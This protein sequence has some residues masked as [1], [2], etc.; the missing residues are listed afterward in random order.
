V[1]RIPP[2]LTAIQ[3]FEIEAVCL[4]EG[5]TP[6]K[7]K[8]CKSKTSRL[9]PAA[10][11]K[12]PLYSRIE[13]MAI[14]LAVVRLPYHL[15]RS[16]TEKLGFAD[17]ADAFDVVHVA[18]P[19]RVLLWELP[20][21]LLWLTVEDIRDGGPR[22]PTLLRARM[23]A[24]DPDATHIVL[25]GSDETFIPKFKEML[26][27][28]AD[29]DPKKAKKPLMTVCK[30]ANNKYLLH[31]VGDSSV[32]SIFIGKDN[33]EGDLEGFDVKTDLPDLESR[34]GGAP[35]CLLND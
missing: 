28:K 29:P 23:P 7:A 33:G 3:L 9:K 8:T 5:E 21:F 35:A 6:D 4:D 26:Y 32:G 13:A 10:Q 16:A 15:K 20:R 14:T 27:G 12:Q 11:V 31:A 25:Q 17:S 24:R 18:L 1:L 34:L 30:R 19:Q 22:N 2:A